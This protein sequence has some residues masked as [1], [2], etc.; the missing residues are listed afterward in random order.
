MLIIKNA[1]AVDPALKT[2][3]RRDIYVDNGVFAAEPIAGAAELDASGL[4]A[5]P[6]FF[7]MHVHFREPGQTDKEDIASGS[8]AAAAGGAAR[9][10]CMANTI[11][12]ID[13]P[14]LVSAVIQK[15][16]S[17]PVR[18]YQ[19]AAVT[20]G[21]LGRELTDFAA[22]KKAGAAALSD[23]GR[24]I[25]DAALMLEAL[26][27]ANELDMLIIAHSEDS[28]LTDGKAINLGA[29]SERLGISGRPA[30]AEEYMVARDAMLASLA[31][32]RVHIAHVSTARSVEI[33]R[34]AKAEGVRISCET[35]PHYFS[36]TEDVVAELGSAAKMYPPLRT[37]K[38]RLAV[39]AGLRDGTIDCIATDH[40][41]HTRAEKALDLEAAPAGVVGLETLLS[42]SLSA[43]YRGGALTLPKLME[44]LS[45]APARL[46]GLPGGSLAP[47]NP[48]DLVLFD[49]REEYR[50][51]TSLFLS[52]G[53]STPFSGKKLSGLVM[54][55]LRA[56]R[57]IY[58]NPRRPLLWTNL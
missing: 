20:K 8:A 12:P 4:V 55:T 11:P 18:V 52:K 57:I 1:L 41:P 5:A 31:G 51:D 38:D 6:A 24:P 23:D 43:L 50:V 34:R 42:A 45:L 33:I 29:V 9:V 3:S 47:G 40:A 53:R 22:L 2:A 26:R 10:L 30:F 46:L 16:K 14:E 25:T 21:L 7:D 36:F 48:A 35:A 58:E 15:S 17:A 54:M 19:A 13:S 39:I 44:K 32:A 28:S 37:E 27:R 56:G 49:P